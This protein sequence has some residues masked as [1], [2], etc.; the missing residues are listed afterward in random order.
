V[1]LPVSLLLGS[2]ERRRRVPPA[3]VPIASLQ[4]HTQVMIGTSRAIVFADYVIDRVLRV[5]P[6]RGQCAALIQINAIV[7]WPAPDDNETG[8]RVHSHF[9]T[10][11]DC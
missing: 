4:L 6:S 2:L 9:R 1:A 11:A 7:D 10:T 3:C 5:N 8:R